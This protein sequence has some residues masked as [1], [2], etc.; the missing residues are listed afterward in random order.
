MASSRAGTGQ[1]FWAALDFELRT[2]CVGDFGVV[3]AKEQLHQRIDMLVSRC[4]PNFCLGLCCTSE[5][6][7]HGICEWLLDT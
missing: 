1:F 5:G 6:N 4:L 3:A 7:G 2:C